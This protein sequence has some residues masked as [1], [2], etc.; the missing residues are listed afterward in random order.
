MTILYHFRTRG[1]GAEAVHISGIVR[2]FEKLGHRVILSSPTGIDPRKSAGASPF[3]AAS[4]SGGGTG[5]L[6]R[7]LP[8]GLFELAEMVY[9]LP[10]FL[11][12]LRL[13][14]RQHCGLIYERHAFFLFSTALVA[15]LR[16]LPLVVEVNE[17][18]GDPRVRAQPLFSA[19]ARWTDRFVFRRAQLVV[20][21]SPH[22]KRRV[23][24][25]GVPEERILL[26]PNAVSEEELAMPSEPAPFALEPGHFKLGF[27]GWLVEWHRLN[28]IIQALAVPEFSNVLLVLIGEG[29]LRGALEEQAHRLGVRLHCTG[30]LPHGA[31]PAALRAMDACLVPHSNNYRSPIKLFEYLAQERPVLAPRTEPVEAVVTDGKEALLF[32]PLD[33]VGF[34]TSLRKLLNDRVLRAQLAAA[35]RKLVEEQH[36]WEKNVSSV[37]ARL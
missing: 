7:F 37:L 5:R 31:I 1:T 26:L 15:K 11:R 8:R 16:R 28:F 20:T 21:V 4:S 32:T 10:A 30:A 19:L 3:R 33:A 14:G 23:L 13:A 12:N 2:A 29:P 24:R 22:L 18:V 27:A 25:Y 9:N 17:L 6:K 35:G 34:Q 36:T